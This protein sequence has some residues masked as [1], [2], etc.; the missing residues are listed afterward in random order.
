MRRVVFQAW[1]ARAP[2]SAKQY[3]AKPT[4]LAAFEITAIQSILSC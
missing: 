1:E 2:L 4:P 3:H